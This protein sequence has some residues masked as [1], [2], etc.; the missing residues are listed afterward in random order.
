MK[1][2]VKSLVLS[3]IFSLFFSS[4]EAQLKK[5]MPPSALAQDLRKVIS[6]YPNRF[7]NITG[8]IIVENTQSTEYKC[9]LPVNDAEESSIT[10]YSSKANKV[11]SWEALMLSTESFEKA[12]QK[13]KSIFSQLNNLVVSLD[14]A[15]FRL[16]GKYES[17]V[18]EMKFTS[19]VFSFTPG[20]EAVRKLKV[21]V[22]MNYELTE[23]K[24]KLLVYDR[25]R[26][27]EERGPRTEGD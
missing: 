19:V 7:S 24:V 23:W 21:E 12:K 16:D 27:D 6:D 5:L 25:E 11:Y 8:D 13:F 17:P 14:N 4:T 22:S 9:I 15:S 1:I 2:A 26:E 10:Q 3:T 20:Q 18:E